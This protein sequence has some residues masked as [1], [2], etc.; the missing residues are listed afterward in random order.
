MFIKEGGHMKI[1]L[2][3]NSAGVLLFAVIMSFL[4]SLSTAAL[5]S[6]TSIK[7]KM[8]YKEIERKRTSNLLKGGVLYAYEGLRTRIWDTQLPLDNNSSFSV[9]VDL[10]EDSIN[11]VRIIITKDITM[12][13]EYS[14]K[15][16]SLS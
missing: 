2:R 5:V 7:A 3:S 1:N 13:S 12:T 8:V 6:V 10:T 9:D 11:D 15:V 4:L 14:I 16:S